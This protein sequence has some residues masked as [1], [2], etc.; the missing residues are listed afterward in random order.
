[1]V[2]L[3]LDTKGACSLVI[4]GDVSTDVRTG[5]GQHIPRI[6]GLATRL[7]PYSLDV[8]CSPT[9]AQYERPREF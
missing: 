3:T 5:D 7:H 2:I 8:V 9:K 1:M 4:C 6:K